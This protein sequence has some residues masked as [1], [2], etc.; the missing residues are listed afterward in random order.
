[1]TD[2]NLDARF[3]QAVA[4]TGAEFEDAV[5]YVAKAWLPA[6]AVVEAAL[7]ERAA[8]DA[9]REILVLSTSCPWKEHLYDLETALEVTPT[10]K[11]CLFEASGTG[12]RRGG[13]GRRGWR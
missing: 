10:I 5:A 1:M 6:R 2:A 9:S 12:G 8:V 13:R 11:F 4:L 3:A 7:A